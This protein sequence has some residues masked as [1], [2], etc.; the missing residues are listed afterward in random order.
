MEELHPLSA[1]RTLVT[2]SGETL[3]GDRIN[4]IL[5]FASVLCAGRSGGRMSLLR[6]DYLALDDGPVHHGLSEHLTLF[7]DRPVWRSVLALYGEARRDEGFRCIRDAFDV[8]AN[9]SRPELDLLLTHPRGA[10]AL[11]RRVR[12]DGAPISGEFLLAE[13]RDL[14]DRDRY[15]YDWFTS[16]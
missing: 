14:H 7:E 12:G 11:C 1:A 15:R 10:W 3:S 16:Y 6:G 13:Y 2:I 8:L 9:H 5:F 4:A